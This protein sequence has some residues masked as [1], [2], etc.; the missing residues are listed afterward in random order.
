MQNSKTGIQTTLDLA[1]M[2]GALATPEM[3]DLR[4]ISTP[5]NKRA[6]AGCKS[7]NM[8]EVMFNPQVNQWNSGRVEK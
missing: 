7:L 6:R 3:W 8:F 5:K 4:G 2:M 1:I